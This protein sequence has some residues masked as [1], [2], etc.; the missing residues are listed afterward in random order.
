LYFFLGISV[1]LDAKR[2]SSSRTTSTGA[3]QLLLSAGLLAPMGAD[4][5]PIRHGKSVRFLSS[6]LLS[7]IIII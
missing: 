5:E 2:H 1:L 6:E 7:Y 4:V 3:A